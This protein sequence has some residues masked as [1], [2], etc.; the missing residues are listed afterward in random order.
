M[1]TTLYYDASNLISDGNRVG[2]FVGKSDIFQNLRFSCQNFQISL[3]HRYIDSNIGSTC[4]YHHF[5]DD[6]ATVLRPL[7]SFVCWRYRQFWKSRFFTDT[8]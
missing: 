1:D 3:R 7:K 4:E 6:I 8:Y 5:F 2:N